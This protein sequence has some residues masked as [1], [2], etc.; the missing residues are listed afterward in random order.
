MI[1]AVAMSEPDAGSALTD[2]KTKGRVTNDKVILN[3]LKDGAPA[4]VMRMVML[5]IA[6][7]PMI[8]ARKALVLFLSRKT[9]QAYLSASRK[10]LW[11]SAGPSCD[12]FF[13]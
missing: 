4:A 5:F 2:L 13:G 7:C 11:V 1:V 12:T 9:R 3:G 8:R 10:V 6:V